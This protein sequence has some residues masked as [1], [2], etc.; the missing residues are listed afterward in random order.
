MWAFVFL[1]AAAFMAALPGRWKLGRAL[2]DQF[3]AAMTVSMPS[4][5]SFFAPNDDDD[6]DEPILPRHHRWPEASQPP[7]P[8][9]QHHHNHTDA[10]RVAIRF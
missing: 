1:L 6:D 4:A 7:P 9:P 3:Q 5:G 8:P 10:P 2:S